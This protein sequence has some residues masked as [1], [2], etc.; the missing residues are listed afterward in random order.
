MVVPSLDRRS[1]ASGGCRENPY[2]LGLLSF[3]LGTVRPGKSTVSI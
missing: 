1:A 2:G 3:S